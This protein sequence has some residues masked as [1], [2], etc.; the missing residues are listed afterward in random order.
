MTPPLLFFALISVKIIILISG[1]F[2]NSYLVNAD[3][4][5]DAQ[6]STWSSWSTASSQSR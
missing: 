2:L 3:I 4:I 1:L 6:L 5:S